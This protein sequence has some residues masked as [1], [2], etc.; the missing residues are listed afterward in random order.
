[1]APVQ[2]RSL[3]TGPALPSL[4]RSGSFIRLSAMERK[5]ALDWDWQWCRR[6]FKIM[7]VRLWWNAPPR[8]E[9]SSGLRCPAGKMRLAA[10]ARPPFRMCVLWYPQSGMLPFRIR[11]RIR[12]PRARFLFRQVPGLG[13]VGGRVKSLRISAVRGA[14]L[15]AFLL[16]SLYG[17]AQESAVSPDP[18]ETASMVRD[19]QDQV[20]QLRT[21]VEQMRAENA[22]SR[23]EMHQL[24]QDLQ[25]TRALLKQPGPAAGTSTEVA[26]V[27]NG[28]GTP[29]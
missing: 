3:M 14:W 28:A 4:S 11:F 1:M 25:A 16:C 22:E 18:G 20:R 10:R 15:S 6:S 24:R 9:R 17:R 23:A 7:A 12:A 29:A 8:A 5:T 27:P 21:L 19:L 2:F 13:G 26:S